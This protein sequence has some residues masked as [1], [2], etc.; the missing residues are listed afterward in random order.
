MRGRH[1][2]QIHLLPLDLVTKCFVLTIR[3]VPTL[4][5]RMEISMSD[6]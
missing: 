1:K 4:T 5:L 6:C 2:R 3:R